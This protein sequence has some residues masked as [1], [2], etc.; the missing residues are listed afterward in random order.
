MSK[1][2]SYTETN[3]LPKK[4]NNKVHKTIILVA[5]SYECETPL[6]NEHRLKQSENRVLKEFFNLNE[7]K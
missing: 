6:E 3:F 1:N 2:A 5:A 7:M 4:L